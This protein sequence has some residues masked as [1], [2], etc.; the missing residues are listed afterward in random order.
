MPHQDTRTPRS[1]RNPKPVPTSRNEVTRRGHP[2]VPPAS[3][4]HGGQWV[5]VGA[6]RPGDVIRHGKR[7]LRVADRPRSTSRDA[8]AIALEGGEVRHAT[9][10]AEVLRRQ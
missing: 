9:P 7:W 1:P 4:A 6:V 10:R 5:P 2:P 3:P 8:L